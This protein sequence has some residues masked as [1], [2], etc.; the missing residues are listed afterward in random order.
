M[1]QATMTTKGQITIPAEIRK[2]LSL[3]AGDKVVFVT[4]E[5]G[6]VVIFPA[7]RE[8]GTLKGMIE[9]PAD[10]VSIDAMDEAIRARHSK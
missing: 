5:S 9:K 2:A 6:E 3:N 8:V 4:R 10:P 7:T 1:A